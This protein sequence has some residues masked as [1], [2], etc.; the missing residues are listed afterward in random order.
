MLRVE[1]VMTHNPQCCSPDDDLATVA[2][3]MW[4]LD[5][6]C[7]P[8]VGDG[9][10]I[11]GMV[12]DR[13]IA[14]AALLNGK[15]LHELRVSNVMAKQIVTANLGD[16]LRTVQELMRKS[17]VRRVP[18]VDGD[19]KVVGIVSLHDLVRAAK[20]ERRKFFP[21]VR[22]KDVALTYAEISEP[23]PKPA[24][25]EKAPADHVAYAE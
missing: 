24:L 5:V 8:I 12:T 4:D 22:M 14:M 18:V 9:R 15:A 16:R 11:A 17:K 25:P 2:N 7:V 1:D 10:R 19:K 21:N 3:V 23:T 6:G 13:D 20:S